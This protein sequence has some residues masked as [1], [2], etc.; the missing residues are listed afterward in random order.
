MV[1]A[2]EAILT[3]ERHAKDAAD[4]FR[5]LGAFR[6]ITDRATRRRV[7]E[8]V[9]AMAEKRAPADDKVTSEPPRS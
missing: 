8:Q 1:A 5:L 7:L 3:R 4:A 2:L 6:S 9:E